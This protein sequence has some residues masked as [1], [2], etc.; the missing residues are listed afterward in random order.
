[1]AFAQFL[2]YGTGGLG[3]DVVGVGP[4]EAN[5]SD[6]QNQDHREHDRVFSDVLT[7]LVGPKHGEGEGH[8]GTIP[9]SEMWRSH[10]AGK[11]VISNR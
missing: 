8:I 2:L 6:D 7:L 9:V 4:D 11:R 10:Y 1:V 5:G 3:E